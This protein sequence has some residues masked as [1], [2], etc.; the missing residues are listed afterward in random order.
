MATR[1]NEPK[2]KLTDLAYQMIE[3]AIVTLRIRPGTSLGDVPLA[4]EP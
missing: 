3:E 1:L 2:A 4:V